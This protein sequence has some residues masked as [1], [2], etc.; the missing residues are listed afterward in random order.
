[1]VFSGILILKRKNVKI[2]NYDNVNGKY[3]YIKKVHIDKKESTII[4]ALKKK[5]NRYKIILTNRTFEY[6]NKTFW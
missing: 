3:N 4:T 1:M 2:Y 5:S 6:N